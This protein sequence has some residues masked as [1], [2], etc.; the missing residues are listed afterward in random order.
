MDTPGYL[1]KLKCIKKQ[2][3]D[4]KYLW[5]Y[6]RW[7]FDGVHKWR[8]K[9]F[10]TDGTFK[11]LPMEVNFIPDSMANIIAIKDVD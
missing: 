3:N 2:R 7:N 4:W 1:F 11:V 5:L 10:Y 9:D 8:L 6:L